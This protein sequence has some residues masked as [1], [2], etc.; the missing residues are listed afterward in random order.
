[1]DNKI[2]LVIKEIIA[3][4]SEEHDEEEYLIEKYLNEFV[5]IN[6]KN[7]YAIS[8]LIIVKLEVP[9]LEY[10]EALSLLNSAINIKSNVNLLLL[11]YYTESFLCL[12]SYIQDVKNYKARNITEQ[13]YLY[14]LEAMYL[15][16][17][18]K[19][20]VELLIN[21]LERNPFLNAARI[22]LI[23][24]YID[25]GLDHEANL[26]WNALVDNIDIIDKID[27]RDFYSVENFIREKILFTEMSCVSYNILTSR[28]KT[29]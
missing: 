23:Q 22:Q 19:S 13:S 4:Y 9:I 5:K 1:M 21:S 26:Q 14:F 24:Y 2:D 25:K 27:E 6:S 3:N 16:S 28:L 20:N 17:I 12:S 29:L 8:K 15:K 7:I 10:D 18:Y 11:K